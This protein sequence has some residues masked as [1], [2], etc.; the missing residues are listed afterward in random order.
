MQRLYLKFKLFFSAWPLF[1][2]LLPLFFIYSG[3]NDLFGFL[4]ASFVLKNLAVILIS[5]LL[6]YI[7][8]Y[9]L[10]K[11]KVTAS[12]F[13]FF[14]SLFFLVFGFIHDSMK[15]LNLPALFSKFT[16]FLAICIFLFTCLFLFL[17]NKKHQFRELFLFLNTL[18]IILI[19]SE[20]PNSV[21]RYKLDKSVHNLIDFRFNVLNEYKPQQ[22][23]PDSLKPDIYFLVFD[24]LA[25]S[26]SISAYIGK[27]NF[28]L[29]SFLTK[30]HFYVIPN[31]KSNYNWTIYSIIST[32]NMEYLPKWIEPVMNDPKV[33]FWGSSS[34]L[35]NSLFS[36]LRQED[37]NIYNYQ[38]I[39]FEN[40]DWPGVSNFND[41]K[42]NHFYFKTLPGR[43]KRDIF[44]NYTKLNISLIENH[45]MR[46]INNRNKRKKQLFDSTISLVRNTAHIRGNPKFVYGHFML[47]HDPYIFDKF[48]N[49]KPPEKTVFIK[50]EDYYN[51]YFEQTL[52]VTKTITNLALYLKENCK[53]NTIIIIEGDHGYRPNMNYTGGYTFQNFNAIYF[54]DQQY[55][56]L[57][58]SISPVNTF[59]IV[60]NKYFN[61]R[62]PL[63]VDSSIIVTEQ[64]ETIKKSAK[65]SR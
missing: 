5:V 3:Y 39:S 24:E 33:Y 29:D 52:F 28:A 56:Q 54:P 18:F 63:L 7:L 44:W 30:Q 51:A 15:Q 21:K 27:D 41:L 31:S 45:Q 43:I 37:Y 34:I 40:K 50:K 65:I 38:P 55:H 47:P 64:N 10:L 13:T 42:D 57:Y 58:D 16:V 62:L 60:L 19:L 11:R 22:K 26:K 8:S 59:R 17:R 48:G 46:L 61:A 36:I 32:L 14:V 49:V 23:T 4:S 6:V 2:I 12:V 1:L 53:R 35:N 9:S 20:I 25:S